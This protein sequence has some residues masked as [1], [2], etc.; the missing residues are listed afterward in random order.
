MYC[1]C[2]VCTYTLLVR[3][4]W[5]IVRTLPFV[6][7]DPSSVGIQAPEADPSTPFS[8]RATAPAYTLSGHRILHPEKHR[9]IIVTPKGV[10][11][12]WK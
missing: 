12:K 6:Q 1:H 8:N 3:S 9:G 10:S 2:I 11:W 7:G 4:N 5:P